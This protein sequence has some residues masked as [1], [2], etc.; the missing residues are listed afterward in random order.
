MGRNLSNMLHHTFALGLIFGAAIVCAGSLQA[1]VE[2]TLDQLHSVF[3]EWKAL[4]NKDYQSTTHEAKAFAN[5]VSN[6][7]TISTHNAGNSSF[8]MGLNKFSDLNTDEFKKLWTGYDAKSAQMHLQMLPT[9]QNSYD[10]VIPDSVDWTQTNCISQVKNQGSCGSCWAFS[11]TGAI[12]A[13]LCGPALSEQDLV[14]CDSGSNGCHGGSMA[15]AFSW[16]HQYGIASET[17]YHYTAGGG[18]TGQ[19]DQMKEKQ[20]VATVSGGRQ[21][22]GESG[23]K[24]AVAGR[25]VSIA[26]D[27][28][29]LQHYHSGILDQAGC[30][31][32]LDHGVLAV[33]YGS[34]PKPYW[35]VKNS[36]GMS[37]GESGYFR[38]A[39]G[40]GMLGIG[41]QSVYPTGVTRV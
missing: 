5:F 13:Q 14:S 7:A 24:S 30:S 33:G 21:V 25:A 6:H 35:K 39:E 34:S 27:A 32:A 8:V 26:V 16:V 29:C 17:G 2:P 9:H 10:D 12:E 38:V 15:Q 20:K 1:E 22:S 36:W 31:G 4:H 11:T 19:C 41:Q 28:T 18:V 23:L 37:W 3:G 40:K